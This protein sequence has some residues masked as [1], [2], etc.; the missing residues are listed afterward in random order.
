MTEKNDVSGKMVYAHRIPR[1][2]W[3][4]PI[5]AGLWILHRCDNRPCVNPAHLFLGDHELNMADMVAKGRQNSRRGES[6]GAAKLSAHEAAS[7]RASAEPGVVLA[8]RHNVSESLI[9]QIRRG[10]KWT[11]L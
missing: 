6:H 2:L 7:I 1:E 10:H 4:G 8:R 3:V 9:S 11:C 5:P